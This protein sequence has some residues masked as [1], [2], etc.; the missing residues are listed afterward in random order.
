MYDQVIKIDPNNIS[1]RLEKGYAL[2]G[3]GRY[4]EAIAAYN[5]YLKEGQDD[6]LYGQMDA[7]TITASFVRLAKVDALKKL[8][9]NEEATQEYNRVFPS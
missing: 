8:G 1:A 9:R 7:F 5:Q 4:E 2:A 3:L 6:K